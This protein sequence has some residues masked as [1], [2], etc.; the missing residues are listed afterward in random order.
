ML[1]QYLAKCAQGEGVYSHIFTPAAINVVTGAGRLGKLSFQFIMFSII[2]SR[3]TGVN[4]CCCSS[5]IYAF[6]SLYC[7]RKEELYEVKTWYDFRFGIFAAC[8]LEEIRSVEFMFAVHNFHSRIRSCSLNTIVQK[9]QKI[10]YKRKAQKFKIWHL[11]GQWFKHGSK[12]TF[13]NKIVI[14]LETGLES[15]I[16]S[17]RLCNITFLV[18]PSDQFLSFQYVGLNFIKVRIQFEKQ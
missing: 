17:S 9:P 6:I 8:C 1:K 2:H 7:E 12:I 14:F 5:C 11:S 10:E 16:T 18:H 3:S 13:P 15:F 4:N